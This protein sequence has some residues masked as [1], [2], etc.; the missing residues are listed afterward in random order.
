VPPSIAVPRISPGADSVPSGIV[1][2]TIKM[3]LPEVTK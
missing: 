2:P 3:P 1:P